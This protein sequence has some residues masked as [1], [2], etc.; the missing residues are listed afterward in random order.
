MSPGHRVQVH[1][2]TEYRYTRGPGT[3]TDMIKNLIFDL[4]GVLVSLDR[5]KCLGN[6]STLLGFDD[7][8]DYLNAY[9]QKGFFAKF[10]NGDIDS[11]QFRDEVRARCTKEGITDELI[12]STLDTFL[13][14]VAPYKVKM[15]LDLKEK[16]NL[17]LLSNVNPIAWRKCCELFL[18]AQGVDIEDVFEKLYLSFEL[19]AS[20]PGT[21]IYEKVLEDSG[22][23]PSE[24]LFIDDSAANIETGRKMGL[25][26]LLYD[27]ES[28]LEDEVREALKELG[29]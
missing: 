19:N 6:F 4:G 28:N 22:V 12:D 11:A 23:E 2:V 18:E 21:A 14:Q 8:G 9:A 27:V 17:F 24:T 13:T 16:Y 29:E 25:N 5:E 7:F 20:K 3:V 10:E 26:V 1:S 15:L